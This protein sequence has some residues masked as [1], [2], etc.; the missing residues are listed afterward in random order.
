M[1]DT[2]EPTAV[3]FKNWNTLHS[4]AQSGE[5]KLDEDA[6]ETLFKACETLLNTLSSQLIAAHRLSDLSGYGTLPSALAM[7][8]K[9]QQKAI[10]G[11]HCASSDDNAVGVLQKHIDLVQ[12]QFDTFRLATAKL[13]DQ[14]TASARQMVGLTRNVAAR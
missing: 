3:D 5:F 8:Q 11:P 7:Q 13:R 1:A 10:G 6:G 12:I 14:D 9:F 2:P 4:Q